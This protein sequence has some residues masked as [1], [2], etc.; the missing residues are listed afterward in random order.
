MRFLVSQTTGV[1]VGLATA[2]LI[3]VIAGV[4]GHVAGV[5][6]DVFVALIFVVPHN[7]GSSAG[8]V[9]DENLEG[10]SGYRFAVR[11]VQ[12]A[13]AVHLLDVAGVLVWAVP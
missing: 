13:A 3:S 11:M 5:R 10:I 7:R 4:I 6:W 9:K 12:I 2:L 8:P 1:A